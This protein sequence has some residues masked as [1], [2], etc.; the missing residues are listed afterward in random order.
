M[1]SAE[2]N[3]LLTRVGPG[4]PM[5]NLLRRYWTPACLSAEL[6]VPDSD[7]LRVRL[8]GEDLI[9]FRDTSGRVGLV[10]N[11]CPHRGASLFFGRNEEDGLRCVY[12]G[13]KFDITGQC[14]DMP[15]EPAGSDF[16]NKVQATAYPT[17]ESGGIVWTYMGPIETM[18]P[19]R[20]FGS[21]SLPAENIAAF[22]QFADCNWVQSMEGN[23][24][25]SHISFLH[26]FDATD[27][28]PD[29]DTDQPGYP[30]QAFSMKIWR[31][32]RAPRMEVLEEWYGFRKAALRRTPKGHT[33]VRINAW[34][35]P[36]IVLVADP[37]F[38]TRQALIVPSD[39]H[40]SMRYSMAT[41]RP[42]NPR[43]LGGTNRQA[44]PQWP[45]VNAGPLRTGSGVNP[46]L[47]T[48]AND[49]KIDR[50]NQRKGTYSGIED[51]ASQD[52]MVTE[53]MGPI[54]DRTQEHL[55]TSDLAIIRMRQLLIG[56]ANGLAR[57]K[58]PPAV[59]PGEYRG[60]RAAE[61]ILEPGENWRI[62]GTDDDPVVREAEGALA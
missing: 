58:E 13:W 35:Y 11:H 53:S 33:H 44:L 16:R 8:M 12:H 6:P 14:V 5:G 52:F 57:G 9:A 49:Y 37:P 39:D 36:W 45:Y 20:D 10:Q 55:G 43:R 25:S 40:T 17:H 38:I 31:Q 21:D 41:T 1:L 18:T 48:L 59:G 2:N 46:R 54:Y 15:N 34:V 22:K 19:F 56:A 42:S 29:D 24:D 26:Q 27:D 7:P 30:S 47:Y 4:T 61:K 23:L 3:E 51:F 28:I 50:A 32:D 60:I 62:L